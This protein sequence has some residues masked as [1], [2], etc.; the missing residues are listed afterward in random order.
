MRGGHRSRQRECADTEVSSTRPV[1]GITPDFLFKDQGVRDVLLIE[2]RAVDAP[3]ADPHGGIAVSFQPL[4]LLAPATNLTRSDHKPRSHPTRIPFAPATSL[5]R[6]CHK[7]HTHLR[8]TPPAPAT[9]LTRTCHK[10]YSHLTQTLL[11]HASHPTC[12]YHTLKLHPAHTRLAPTA[13]RT[14]TTRAS[15]MH[16]PLD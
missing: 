10:P 13:H 14:R 5:T 6:A 1:D 3:D 11:A 2:G 15:D 7:P 12:T 9:N 8:H 16:P 4:T